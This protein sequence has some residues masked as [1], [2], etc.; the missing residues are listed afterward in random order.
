[1]GPSMS[2]LYIRGTL[3]PGCLCSQHRSPLPV[4]RPGL[5]CLIAPS[6]CA[7]PCCPGRARGANAARRERLEELRRR[8]REQAAA[9]RE[10]QLAEKQAYLEYMLALREQVGCGCR[11]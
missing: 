3:V 7:P 11:R 10:K 6:P 5:P 9:R 1:M 8:G 2:P 4:A